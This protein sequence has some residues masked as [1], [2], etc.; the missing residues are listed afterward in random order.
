MLKQQKIGLACL[1][2]TAALIMG[3]W[4]STPPG[5]QS[6]ASVN[7]AQAADNP[8]VYVT[9]TGHKYHTEGC[10]YLRHSASPMKLSEAVAKGYTP[11]SKCDPPTMATHDD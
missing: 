8:I 9:R 4:A 6:A 11:C 1:A 3:L 2:F 5:H 10:P 7:A